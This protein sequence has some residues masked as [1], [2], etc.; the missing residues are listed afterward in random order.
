MTI[1]HFCSL[2]ITWS[3]YIAALPFLINSKQWSKSN[4][5]TMD[6]DLALEN[7]SS[8]AVCTLLNTIFFLKA[9]KYLNI[10]LRSIK[11]KV[12][13]WKIE[14]QMLYYGCKLSGFGTTLLEIKNAV[15]VVALIFLMHN[16]LCRQPIS[17]SQLCSQSMPCTNFCAHVML[18]T[19]TLHAL[20]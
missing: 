5:L 13:V 7:S 18:F 2:Y 14:D 16:S 1:L 4:I 12:R 11:L 20:L 3:I 6:H 10:R 9:I 15:V 8:A 19:C 17:S